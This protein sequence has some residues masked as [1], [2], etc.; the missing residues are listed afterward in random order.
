MYEDY[1]RRL[2]KRNKRIASLWKL[3]YLFVALL[4][5]L[6]L[7][8]A[9]LAIAGTVTE[10]NC[11]QSVVYGE[12]PSVFG[13][14][15]FKDVSYRYR[16]IEGEWT[17][18]APKDA[19]TYE[20]QAVSHGLAGKE[21]VSEVRRFSILPAP[22][23]VK[24][25]DADVDFG[26]LPQNVW[27]DALKYGDKLVAGEFVWSYDGNTMDVLPVK[28]QLRVTDGDGRDVTANYS[29][30]VQ[31]KK[32]ICNPLD[33]QA[34][35]PDAS[36]IYDGR[37]HTA[38]DLTVTGLLN[39]HKFT[40]VCTPAV[41]EVG[42]ADNTLL[43]FAIRDEDGNDV[44]EHNN[45]SAYAGKLTVS[46]RPLAL[47]TGSAVWTYDGREHSLDEVS[48]EGLAEGHALH[49]SRWEVLT[50][51]AERDNSA[52]FS[53]TDGDGNDVTHNYEV[54][55]RLGRIAVAKRSATIRTQGAEA[56]YDAEVHFDDSA[57]TTDGLAEGDYL[58]VISA[59]RQ[60]LTDVGK[61]T[62]SVQ[63]TVVNV[64]GTDVKANY[65][66]KEQW[67]VISVTQRPVTVTSEGGVWTYD[68]REHS[69][70]EGY[71]VSGQVDGHTVTLSDW[72]IIVNAGSADNKPKTVAV[73]D[74]D[75]RDV[76]A[77]YRFGYVNGKL[78]VNK[79]IFEVQ[80]G[81]A[82]FVHTG[83]PNKFLQYD[84]LP[85][86]GADEGLLAELEHRI[87][88][89]SSD[90]VTAVTDSNGR[91]GYA[92]NVQSFSIADGSGR[93]VS[94]NY[95]VKG[96]W[97]QI[98]VKA[99][100]KVRVYALSK[101]YDGT[102]LRYKPTDW[103][104]ESVPVGVQKE[105]VNAELCGSLTEVGT[106]S[107]AQVAMQSSFFVTDDAGKN[108]LSDETDP[109]RVDLVGV[110]LTVLARPVTVTS[111]SVSQTKGDSP[112]YGNS[113]NCAWISSGT[114]L[115]GHEISF[116]ITGVLTL[117]MQSAPNTV[118][119]KVFDENKQD[120][121]RFYDFSYNYGTLSWI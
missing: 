78:V 46:K 51:V 113:E 49:S 71:T 88:G 81:N 99:P 98:R 94:S 20:V 37:P 116:D 39:G 104:V 26:K 85:S 61:A 35:T 62:N 107:L 80:T 11:A 75:G 117:D 16:T 25:T 115:D 15:V 2:A 63:Y 43:S 50:N 109:N 74:A 60:R 9:L 84:L 101:I 38:S 83:K 54:D 27:A 59:Y 119:A 103:T 17:A 12:S 22:L 58:Q 19:G 10:I 76:T 6:A 68:G 90:G 111:V 47:S 3:R 72:A 70:T 120:V 44:T 14:A 23:T 92:D 86:S 110:P 82:V 89:V 34:T 29:I 18:V 32:I 106:L 93:D 42:S 30:T 4:F 8:S 41:T 40:N 57:P 114:L 112:L 105:W 56:V 67:G 95:T 28:E 91:Q 77:N 55:M 121:S 66:I 87:T 1:E 45:V 33:V 73:A 21:R 108:L 48:A 52:I 96:K 65:D 7:C 102:E 5:A 69:V 118:F 53:V 24:V 100:I 64:E 31:S 97:G 36:W 13:K 79:R